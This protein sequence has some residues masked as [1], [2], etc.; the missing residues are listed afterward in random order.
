MLADFI[1]LRHFPEG[2]I[3]TDPVFT[4][5]SDLLGVFGHVA[6]NLVQAQRAAFL[7]FFFSC[8][9]AAPPFKAA[10]AAYGSNPARG[11]IGAA[12][13]GLCH[14]PS[15]ASSELCL[16]PTLQLMAMPDP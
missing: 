14:S 2:S 16:P 1:F 5:D 3:I 12:A 15:N 10:P 6:E 8:S 9:P 13:A 7:F 4:H 11:L